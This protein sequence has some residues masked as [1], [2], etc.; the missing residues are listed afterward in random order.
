MESVTQKI[1]EYRK[2]GKPH[3][4]RTVQQFI[5]EMGFADD[6]YFHLFPSKQT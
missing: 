2:A 5:D 4:W 6:E 1:S 3:T